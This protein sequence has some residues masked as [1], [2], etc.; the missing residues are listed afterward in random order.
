MHVLSKDQIYQLIRNAHN[1]LE[2]EYNEQKGRKEE[3]GKGKQKTQQ[4]GEIPALEMNEEEKDEEKGWEEVKRVRLLDVG[5]G[6]GHM[7]EK[8][9]PFFEGVVATEVMQL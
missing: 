5:A 7:T 6:S 8:M 4:G 9:I 2:K 1:I 3:E